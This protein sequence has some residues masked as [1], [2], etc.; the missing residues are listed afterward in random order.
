[1]KGLLSRLKRRD[2]YIACRINQTH[3][4]GETGLVFLGMLHSL[5]SSLDKGIRVVYLIHPPSCGGKRELREILQRRIVAIEREILAQVLR[6]TGGNKAK[7][8]RR[9]HIDYKTIH[10]KVKQCGSPVD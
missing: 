9:L 5:A 1:M 4:A 3:R 7:A 10:S 6:E 8:A 2:E